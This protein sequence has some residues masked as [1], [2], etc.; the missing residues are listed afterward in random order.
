MRTLAQALLLSIAACVAALTSPSASAATSAFQ[1]AADKA[2]IHELSAQFDNSLDSE[3]EKSF[4]DTF[5]PDGV[6]QGFWGDS[7]GKAEVAKAFHFMLST[8]ARDKRHT[9]SNH[10]INVDGNRATMYSYLTVFDRKQLALTGTATFTD[11]LEKRGGRWLFVRRVLAT[12]PNVQPV[13]DSLS[14]K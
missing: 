3:D 10:Q 9:V 7:K 6:L 8:F 13:I 1:I 12:D 5:T 2:E 4:V 14:K 11:T